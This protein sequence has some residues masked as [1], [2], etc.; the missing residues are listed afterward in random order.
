MDVF[1]AKQVGIGGFEKMLMLKRVQGNVL[2]ARGLP[3]MTYLDRVRSAGGLR[4]PNIAQLLDVGEVQ[5]EL[6]L[7]S[8]FV[9][10]PTLGALIDHLFASGAHVPLGVAC[11]VV[12]EIAQAV[13][14]AYWAAD[15][16]GQ[17]LGVA[18]GELAPHTIAIGRDGSVK[19]IDYGFAVGGL[20]QPPAPDDHRRDLFALGELLYVLLTGQRP[21]AP[22]DLLKTRYTPVQRLAPAQPPVLAALVDQ[23]LAPGRED[24]PQTG[25]QVAG[26]IT[27]FMR[28]YG[29]ERRRTTSRGWSRASPTRGATWPGRRRNPRFRGGRRGRPGCW[30]RLRRPGR[31]EPCR[32]SRRPTTACLSCR[33]GPAGRRSRRRSRSARAGRRSSRRC[34]RCDPRSRRCR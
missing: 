17:R 14:H 19:V 9:N 29:I 32:Q 1:L 11:F 12:R 4:H 23:M 34:A 26:A 22:N 10:G 24:C 13:H 25:Q 27:D 15:L 28:S 21:F 33:I 16:G 7:A 8:E 2:E 6:Y 5:G 3:V 30:R 31:L 18:H 20:V